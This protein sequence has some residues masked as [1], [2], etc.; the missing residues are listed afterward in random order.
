MMVLKEVIKCLNSEIA[1]EKS[2]NVILVSILNNLPGFL[3]KNDID[4]DK[5]KN[6]PFLKA[7]MKII[8][9]KIKYL[10]KS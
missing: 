2:N 10:L 7:N 5:L 1:S 8:R 3:S 6:D 4:T 9:Q